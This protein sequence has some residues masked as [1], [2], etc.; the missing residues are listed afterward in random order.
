M[1]V[2]IFPGDSKYETTLQETSWPVWN[3]DFKFQLKQKD[4]KN[5][6]CD[7]QSL[8][9]GHF[10]S[11]TIYALLEPAK[12]ESEKRKGSKALDSKNTNKVGSPDEPKA[13]GGFLEKT[14]SSFKATKAEAA[15]QKSVLE[16]RRTLGAATWNFDSKLFQNDLK[17]GLI[18]TPDIW[19]PINAIAS[20]LSS[21]DSRVSKQSLQYFVFG[22]ICEDIAT[23][24][25]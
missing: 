22:L 21:S 1:Q 19:R 11:L 12:Q 14:F 25:E 10:L 17:N 8:V 20:G 4:T 13:K 23:N 9:A 2:K 5:Q 6:K 3:E 15:V 18:G 7:L 24:G 16:K